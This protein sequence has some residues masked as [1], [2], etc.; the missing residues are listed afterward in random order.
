MKLKCFVG[1]VFAL[2]LGCAS[3]LGQTVASSVVGTVVDPADAAVAGA[4]VTLTN[5]GTGAVHQASTDSLGTYRFVELDPGP[6]SL[7]IKAT[8]FKSETVNGIQVA[9]QE[10]HDAGK[11]V[12]QI[13]SLAESISVTADA[14]QVQLASSDKSQ[15][16][17]A[18][19]LKDLTLKGRDLFGYPKL[20]PGVI[21]T[22]GSRDVTSHGAIK[23]G[24]AHV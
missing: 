2:A 9:M 5:T 24:R 21:D 13:G 17:D 18:G 14:A 23:I 7:T 12:L 20:V 6:Y 19:A 22:A 15:T 4:Q 11:A 3:L 1:I 10:V 8:G 16:V